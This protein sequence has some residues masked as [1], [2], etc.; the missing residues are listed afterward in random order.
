MLLQQYGCNQEIKDYLDSLFEVLSLI[1]FKLSHDQVS[2]NDLLQN[3][4]QLENI[5][6][7]HTFPLYFYNLQHIYADG[8]VR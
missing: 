2:K 7:I 5:L 4:L 8:D 1:L 6:L 3:L